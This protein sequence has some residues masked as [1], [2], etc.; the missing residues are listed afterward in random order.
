[1]DIKSNKKDQIREAVIAAKREWIKGHTP[2]EFTAPD[3]LNA[4]VGARI[5]SLRNGKG[6]SLQDVVDLSGER[7]GSKAGLSLKELG[8]ENL[9]I[10]QPH[11]LAKIL[12]VPIGNLI[13]DIV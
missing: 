2:K 13:K 6:M 9:T 1:M 11:V 4:L 3:T 12:N 8:E 5:R 10:Y 7:L